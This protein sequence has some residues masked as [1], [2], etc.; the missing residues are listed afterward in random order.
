VRLPLL[1]AMK[2]A[3]AN[4]YYLPQIDILTRSRPELSLTDEHI[5]VLNEH[6]AEFRAADLTVRYD[7][8]ERA[9]G[10]IQ[11]RWTEREKFDR[12]GME[13]VSALLAG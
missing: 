8:I 11:R 5:D 12:N 1:R 6:I 9:T 10:R 4:A 3:G 2:R 7:I 13:S